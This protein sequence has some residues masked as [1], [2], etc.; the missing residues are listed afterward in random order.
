MTSKKWNDALGR[1]VVIRLCCLAKAVEK[2]TG[3]Q[4]YEVLDFAPRWEWDCNEVI[5]KAQPD[6]TVELE[7]RG[8]PPR[9]LLE[10]FQKKGIP[11]HNLP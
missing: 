3:E 8:P 5:Q 10:R 7:E 1:M 2:L 9:W 11:V 4:L 6:G